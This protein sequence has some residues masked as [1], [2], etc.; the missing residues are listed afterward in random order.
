MK[1]YKL[2][3]IPFILFAS[4]III[5]SCGDKASPEASVGSDAKA[6]EFAKNMC[7]MAEEIGLDENFKLTKDYLAKKGEKF[8]DNALNNSDDLIKLLK[9]VDKHMEGLNNDQKTAFTKELMKAIIDTKCSDIFFKGIQYQDLGK[10]IETMEK[11]ATTL[12][13]GSEVCNC[14]DLLLEMTIVAKEANGDEQKL[15]A[16]E[17]KYKKDMETCQKLFT[18]TKRFKDEVAIEKELEKCPSYKKLKKMNN[19]N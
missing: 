15:E 5:S 13:K 14:S 18:D 17:K 8:E 9:Q 11:D 2:F 7:K 16:L 4:S 6:K 10:L 3:R 12:I 1:K 19:S